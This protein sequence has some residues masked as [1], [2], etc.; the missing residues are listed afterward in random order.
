MNGSR[1]DYEL[2]IIG[3][4]FRAVTYDNV[5]SE[6]PQ[7]PDILAFHGIRPGDYQS[8]IQKHF[9]QRGHGYPS[10]SYQMASA[11]GRHIVFKIRHDDAPILL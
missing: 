2:N 10:D 8:H 3:N 11:A 7:I 1:A 9:R 6:I 4:V 5:D